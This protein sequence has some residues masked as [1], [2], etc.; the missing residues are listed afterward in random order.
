MREGTKASPITK[1]INLGEK[2]R[3]S[4]LINLD[5]RIRTKSS[6]KG[7]DELVECIRSSPTIKLMNSEGI[8]KG[9]L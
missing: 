9:R 8:I 2:M 5:V 1:L 6:L 7:I 4:E 3:F